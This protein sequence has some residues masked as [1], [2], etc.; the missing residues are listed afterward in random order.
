M[1]AIGPLHDRRAV[2][3][4]PIH[5][6]QVRERRDL[7]QEFD[8]ERLRGGRGLGAGQQEADVAHRIGR[9]AAVDAHPH[10]P[11][12]VAHIGDDAVRLR[13]AYLEVA[14]REAERPVAVPEDRVR[15][16]GIVRTAPG[17]RHAGVLAGQ[18]RRWIAVFHGERL[19]AAAFHRRRPPAAV[20]HQVGERKLGRPVGDAGEVDADVARPGRQRER[21][22]C[23]PRRR[24]R[25]RGRGSS[26][27]GGR[28]RVGERGDDGQDGQQGFHRR[29][30]A[31]AID[32]RA[33]QAKCLPGRA[34]AARR[35]AR[36]QLAFRAPSGAW[37]WCR[38]GP[39]TS[40]PSPDPA[41]RTRA[42][43][44][45]PTSTSRRRR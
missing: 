25:R 35:V 24:C 8:V 45:G 27:G 20:L 28:C 21:Q 11:A 36:L 7:L 41:S 9:V 3:G 22:R 23:R 5:E 30:V 1:R 34:A 19:V 39:G 10:L 38:A 2:R 13:A 29:I 15:A 31:A 40:A 14:E 12:D 42:N 4:A 32:A 18:Q 17:H 16:G 37:R 6:A 44:T 33:A 43:P 26:L